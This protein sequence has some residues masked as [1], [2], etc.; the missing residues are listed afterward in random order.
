MQLK[1]CVHIDEIL[2]KNNDWTL[3][4]D[5]QIVAGTFYATAFVFG[6]ISNLFVIVAVIKYKN[7]LTNFYNVFIANLALADLLISIGVPIT[8]YV[9]F[10]KAWPFGS[11]ACRIIPFVQGL[12]V[13]VSSFTLSAIAIDR[14]FQIVKSRHFDWTT[15]SSMAVVIWVVSCFI[16]APM[17]INSDLKPGMKWLKGDSINP[18]TFGSKVIEK[19]VQ[20][21]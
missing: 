9:D 19:K 8:A 18:K 21:F 20:K 4:M 13:L 12:S 17:A 1:N 15:S 2:Q 6:F 11:L 10:Y 3:R 14:F 7:L 5:F 16:S